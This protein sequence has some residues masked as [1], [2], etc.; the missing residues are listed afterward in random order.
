M[1][2]SAPLRDA[3]TGPPTTI[4]QQFTP[5]TT[6]PAERGHSPTPPVDP[7]MMH[8]RRR[9]HHCQSQE[10]WTQVDPR[11][12]GS[13]RPTPRIPKPLPNVAHQTVMSTSC[14]PVKAPTASHAPTFGGKRTC[15]APPHSHHYSPEVQL[16]Q[17]E[18]QQ[19]VYHH[20]RGP[21]VEVHY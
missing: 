2:L 21:G 17:P 12:P 3:E 13:H 18:K 10:Q 15:S 5:A 7:A 19:S 9:R 8:L 20:H 4:S 6:S 11:A 1:S 14:R 16:S